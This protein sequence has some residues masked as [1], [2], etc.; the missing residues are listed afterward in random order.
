YTSASEFAATLDSDPTKVWA[1][2]EVLAIAF[3]RPPVF[4]PGTSFDY[5]NTNYVLLGLIAE[6]V[7]GQPL[8]Q[9]FQD[10]SGC[11][12]PRCRP[13]TTPP[14]PL[15][16]HT[17]TC[18]ADLSTHWLTRSAPRTCGP[19]QPPERC[20]PSTTQ[21]RTPRTPPLRGAPSPLETTWPPGS[22]HWS[23]ATS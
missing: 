19:P 10:S 7:G 13:P 12:R 14:S 1:P 5:S 6:K 2:Q 11:G 8:A 23:R 15:P 4:P 20:N 3:G 16:T 22:K 18:T 17:A 9:Q 21:T